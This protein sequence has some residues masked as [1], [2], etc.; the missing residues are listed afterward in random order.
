[1]LYLCFETFYFYSDPRHLI[2]E[3]NLSKTKEYKKSG[4]SITLELGR[5]SIFHILFNLQKC[6]IKERNTGGFT[7]TACKGM[8]K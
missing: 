7:N 6:L 8:H 1:M 3:K 4:L 5:L 2:F